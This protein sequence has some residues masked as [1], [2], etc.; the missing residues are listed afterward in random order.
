MIAYIPVAIC[1]GV[2]LLLVLLL[3]VN[4]AVLFFI[5]AASV[6]LQQFLD[7]DATRLVNSLLPGGGVDYM[8]LMVLIV[9]IV[10]ATAMFAGTAKKVMLPLHAVLA[11]IT[12][13]TALLTVDRFL[14]SS[15]LMEFSK[16]AVY[17]A[18]HDYQT[19][20]VGLGIVLGLFLLKSGNKSGEHKKGKH[21]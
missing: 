8:S 9:P 14:P 20:I 18:V 17:D 3:R 15:W 12:G 11:I 13:L 6:L 1:I 10:V 16:T 2:P 19:V 5:V 7:P 4:S 21:H